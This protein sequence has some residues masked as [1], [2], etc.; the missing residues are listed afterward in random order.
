MIEFI[1]IWVKIASHHESL[2]NQLLALNGVES[3]LEGMQSYVNEANENM[4]KWD[5][6]NLMIKQ[7]QN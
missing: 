7:K 4:N 1:N 5:K 2:V 3:A 6:L